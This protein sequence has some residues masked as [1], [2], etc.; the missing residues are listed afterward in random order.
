MSKGVLVIGSGLMAQEYVKVLGGLDVSFDV[1]GRGVESAEV[2]YNETG[3]SVVAGGIDNFIE[4]TSVT[5]YSHFIVA[6]NVTQLFGN[7]VSL[8]KAGAKNIL[9]EKPCVLEQYQLTELQELAE[10]EG[11]NVYIAYN[12]R[13]FSSVIKAKQL[14]EEDGGLEMVKFDFTE[15]SHVIEKLEKDPL[16]KERWLLANSTHIIDLAFFFS[17][18]PKELKTV[19]AGSLD[20]HPSGQV[21]AGV[22]VSE[23]GVVL[24]YGSDWGSAGRWWVELFTP[25]RKLRLCPVETVVET[26]RGTVVENAVEF[27]D[28]LD[29][30]YKPGLFLQTKSFLNG[31]DCD[32]KSL[33]QLLTSFHFYCQMAGYESVE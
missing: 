22:G 28:S 8:L 3:V 33:D 17:G 15:W 4:A 21:F 25:K 5:S 24:S 23:K 19:V 29:K 11:G 30:E 7:V 2:F 6:T 9:V 20:W 16:E 26:I 14:I 12:R 18:T 13:F 32:L 31:D 1:V 10:E 27:D